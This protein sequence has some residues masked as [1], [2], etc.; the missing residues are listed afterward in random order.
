MVLLKRSIA[1]V[2]GPATLIEGSCEEDIVP[3]ANLLEVAKQYLAR[4]SDGTEPEEL[5]SFF[6]PDVVQEEFPD[7]CHTAR[8]ETSKP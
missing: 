4:L 2:D 7:C 6:A 5:D 1:S 8:R 3:D